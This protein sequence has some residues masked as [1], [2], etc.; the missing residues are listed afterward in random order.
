VLGFLIDNAV[1]AATVW[2]LAGGGMSRRG[3]TL[4]ALAAARIVSSNFN[5][6]CNRFVVFRRK[7]RKGAHRSYFSYFA[8]VLAIGAASYALTAAFGA[9]FGVEGVK[10][11]AVKIVVD[12]VLFFVGYFIQKRFVFG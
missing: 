10:I 4:V 8:L 11:T 2:A 3:Y 12:A 6:L 5:Y 9:L 7:R 1:Y